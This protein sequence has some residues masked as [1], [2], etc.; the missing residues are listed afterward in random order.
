[1]QTRPFSFYE[2]ERGTN[3]K[4]TMITRYT[5]YSTSGEEKEKVN[6]FSEKLIVKREGAGKRTIS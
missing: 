3:G 4:E 5:R 1:M 6:C 2:N